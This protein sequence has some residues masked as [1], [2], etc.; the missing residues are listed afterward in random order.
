M[1]IQILLGATVKTL[2]TVK[3]SPKSRVV[4]AVIIVIEIFLFT[5]AIVVI[6]WKEIGKEQAGVL[7]GRAV[8]AMGFI[9]SFGKGVLAASLKHISP[10]K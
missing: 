8:H 5:G 3:K 4:H 6:F 10:L 7:L 2:D 9:W 1:F